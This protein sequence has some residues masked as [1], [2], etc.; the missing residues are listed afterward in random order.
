MAIIIDNTSCCNLNNGN[1]LS[2]IIEDSV[3]S[4]QKNLVLG[5]IQEN[6]I[7]FQVQKCLPHIC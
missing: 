5:T 3:L 2:V 4:Q 7:E 1:I 6:S